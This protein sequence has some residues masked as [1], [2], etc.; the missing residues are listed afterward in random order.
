MIGAPPAS[1]AE[2]IAGAIDA[3][4]YKLRYPAGD[5]AHVF[6]NGRAKVSDEEWVALGRRMSDEDYMAEMNRIFG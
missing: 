4:E 6:L 2:T 3:K 5:G 1:T